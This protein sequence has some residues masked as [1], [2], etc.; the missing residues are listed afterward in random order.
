MI[1]TS[2][3]EIPVVTKLGVSTTILIVN[4]SFPSK[5]ILSSIIV[6]SKHLL[7]SPA[8]IV[9]EDGMEDGE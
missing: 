4:D 5:A 6:T 1:V 2:D 3:S 9:R 7:S 8:G